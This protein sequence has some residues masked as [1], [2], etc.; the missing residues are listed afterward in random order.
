MY[1]KGAADCKSDYLKIY[2]THPQL[3]PTIRSWFE[4]GFV[5]NLIQADLLQKTADDR[6]EDFYGLYDFENAFD[7]AFEQELQSVEL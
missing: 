6:K 1:F 7:V 2:T 4:R 5:F 3:V